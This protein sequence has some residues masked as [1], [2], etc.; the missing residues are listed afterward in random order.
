MATLSLCWRNSSRLLSSHCQASIRSV[1]GTMANHY[2]GL[3]LLSAICILMYDATVVEE[4]PM[5]AIEFL[6]L[7][8]HAEALNGLLYLSG[9]CWTD[10]WR[11]IPQGVPVPANHFGVAVAV[12]IAWEDTNRRHHLT[13]RIE[14][15]DGK[16]VGKVEGDLEMGRPP[17]IPPGSDQRAVLA[18]N[19]D[20]QFP[21]AGGYRIVAQLGEET[22]SV[23]FRVHDEPRPR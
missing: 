8:N 13:I 7:A 1:L 20:M 16:E 3:T 2:V 9:G 12:L 11:G 17:G 23:S 10:L 6:A 18:L 22:R 21:S 19:A 4:A 5:P 14:S 15:E